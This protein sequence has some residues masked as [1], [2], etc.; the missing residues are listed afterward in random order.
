MKIGLLDH[1]GYGNLGDAATQDAVIAGIRKRLPTAD[2]VGF[3][4]IPSDTT[5]RHGIPCYPILRWYPKPENNG[6]ESF[7][8][9]HRVSFKSRLKQALKGNRIVYAL[10]KPLQE[11][12]REVVFLFRSY[13]TLGSLDVLIISGGGQLAELWR[14]PW[15]HPFN[16]LK[17]SVLTKLAGKRLY[18]LNVG[19]GPL[20][21][22]LSKLFA[23]WSMRLADYRSFRDEDSRQLVRAVGV[24]QDLEV[25]PDSAYALDVT[26]CVKLPQPGR[27]MPIVGLNPI[28]FCDPR[29]WPRKD[30]KVYAE[31]LGKITRFSEWL[32]EQGYALRMF[33]TETSVDALALK[34]LENR[35]RADSHPPELLRQIFQPA[36]ECVDDV[37]REMSGFDFVVT[38]KY[39]GIIFSQL[40]AK[41]V[42]SLSYHRKMDF[43]MRAVGQ[44]RFRADVETFD[45]DWLVAAFQALVAECKTIK[46]STAT[47]VEANAAALSRQFD[48]LFLSPGSSSSMGSQASSVDRGLADQL[49]R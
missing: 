30:A 45:L 4:F 12:V 18:F 26:N 11:I 38:S 43:A 13:R 29:L 6:D 42:I 44:E 33:T 5:K 2:L 47:A 28:G 23:R 37:L 49:T 17:F 34:D 10:A 32:L 24:K 25:F 19:A 16:I 22:P 31:Y 15:S 40:L 9:D 36:S 3:S 8:A 35:L 20:V 48:C 14:G 27:L 7:G 41:P 39:H 1:M 21:H 46:C